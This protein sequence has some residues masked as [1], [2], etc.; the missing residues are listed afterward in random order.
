MA[1]AVVFVL[2]E[3]DATRASLAFLLGT[4]GWTVRKCRSADELNAALP[5][6]A[7][8][9]L[10]LSQEMSDTSGLECLAGLRARGISLPAV[11]TAEIVTKQLRRQA[12][13]LGAV[14]VDAL[15]VAVI[16]EALSEVLRGGPRSN[17]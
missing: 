15:S 14:V 16:P 13:R 3:D 9:C 17:Q 12:A 10:L 11:I 6:E 5:P 7:V 4:H 1:D 2:Y 8:G